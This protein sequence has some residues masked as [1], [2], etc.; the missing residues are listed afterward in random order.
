MPSSLK[1][2]PEGR[3]MPKGGQSAFDFYLNFAYMDAIAIGFI[4]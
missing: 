1:R 4:C 3:V 2:V